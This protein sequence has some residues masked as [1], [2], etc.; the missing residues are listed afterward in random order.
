[1]SSYCDS[2]TDRGGPN[3]QL[4]TT[5]DKLAREAKVALGRTTQAV[6]V[7]S[8]IN[9]PLPFPKEEIREISEDKTVERNLPKVMVAACIEQHAALE[10]VATPESME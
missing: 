9:N 10:P 2:C 5:K 8:A 7:L 3:C 6:M 4:F 1:M